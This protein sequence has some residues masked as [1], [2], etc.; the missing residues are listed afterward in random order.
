M[1]G[2]GL[3]F[4][5]DPRG[6]D[7]M[8]G[9]GD[10]RRVEDLRVPYFANA[11]PFR[12]R[13]HHRRRSDESLRHGFVRPWDAQLRRF[14]CAGGLRVKGVLLCFLGD[15][16]VGLFPL[17]DAHP[18]VENIR[19]GLEPPVDLPFHLEERPGGGLALRFEPIPQAEELL[20]QRVDFR[21]RRSIVD[22]DGV[23]LLQDA[24]GGR[25]FFRKPL[26]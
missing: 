9:A 21:E 19:H 12:G 23:D 5:L 13:G 7:A 15:E 26:G 2:G 20:R 25:S 10:D 4:S 22:G 3:R 1:R 16:I 11:R 6:V 8:V 24:R 18:H 14:V 17:E